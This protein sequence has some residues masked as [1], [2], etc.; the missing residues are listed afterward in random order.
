MF[1]VY[2][3]NDLQ[4]MKLLKKNLYTKYEGKQ[5]FS[6]GNIGL[7]LREVYIEAFGQETR[8]VKVFIP[9]GTP[10]ESDLPYPPLPFLQLSEIKVYPVPEYGPPQFKVS[11]KEKKLE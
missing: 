2:I 3:G 8:Y 11:V 9:K 1:E 4:N 6:H 5:I 10:S 7:L